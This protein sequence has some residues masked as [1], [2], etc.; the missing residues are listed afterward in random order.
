M[1]YKVE[2]LLYFGE[3]SI[4][5]ALCRS[6]FSIVTLQPNVKILSLDYISDHFERFPV[7]WITPALRL[8]RKTAGERLAHRHMPLIA[9]GIIVVARS[10]G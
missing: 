7:P 8:L 5:L 4:R 1:E 10:T 2:H 3:R 6:G 9:S